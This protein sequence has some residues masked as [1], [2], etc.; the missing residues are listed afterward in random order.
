M[1]QMISDQNFQNDAFRPK[2]TCGKT[3]LQH[4]QGFP[5]QIDLILIQNNVSNQ[6]QI[7]KDNETH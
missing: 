4:L 6:I 7:I 3:V 1:Q 5:H 2:I